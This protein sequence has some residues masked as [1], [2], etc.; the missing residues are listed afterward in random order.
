MLGFSLNFSLG[1]LLKIYIPA[2]QQNAS[3]FFNWK[4]GYLKFF[5]LNHFYCFYLNHKLF[6][7][8]ST[9][10]TSGAAVSAAKFFRDYFSWFYIFFFGSL[11]PFRAKLYLSGLGNRI[12]LLKESF[13]V[14]K[15]GYAHKIRLHQWDESMFFKAYRK[16]QSIFIRSNSYESLLTWIS[17]FRRLKFPDCYNGNGV[18]LQ[19]EKLVFRFR[20]R[21][22]VL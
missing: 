5:F 9:S 22:G 7:L 17:M 11:V 19:D 21:W 20:K 4:L 12:G 2:K 8:T 14:V 16:K 1:S 13:L 3:I 15:L 6:F 10:T 18:R